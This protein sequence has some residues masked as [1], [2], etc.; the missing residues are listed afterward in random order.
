VGF[1]ALAQ[2]YERSVLRVRLVTG[3]AT[4]RGVRIEPGAAETVSVIIGS[5]DAQQS[6]VMTAI[7]GLSPRELQVVELVLRG[8]CHPSRCA[9]SRRL[10]EVHS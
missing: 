4:L 1:T 10:A 8:P 3:W 9:G 2:L 5:P 6:R 7:Y